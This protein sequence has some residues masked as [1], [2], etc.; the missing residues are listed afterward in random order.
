M[1]FCIKEMD[2]YVQQTLF[3]RTVDLYYQQMVYSL[4]K[5]FFCL[6]EKISF[7]TVFKLLT[8]L[9][10]A[11]KNNFTNLHFGSKCTVGLLLLYMKQRPTAQLQRKNTAGEYSA[12]RQ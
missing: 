5:L 7:L 2:D 6:Y 8:T 9:Y 11:Y 12:G 4:C 3:G 1:F 10:F